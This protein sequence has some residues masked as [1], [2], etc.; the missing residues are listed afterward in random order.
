MRVLLRSEGLY[1]P[2][3]W[4]NKAAHIM[5]MTNDKTQHFGFKYYKAK[6]SNSNRKF[7]QAAQDYYRLA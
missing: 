6:V 2:E 4:I 1:P 7:Q 3:G 5:H